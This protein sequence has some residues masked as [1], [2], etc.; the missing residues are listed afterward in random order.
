MLFKIMKIK[1][2]VVD[3]NIQKA[4]DMIGEIV[5]AVCDRFPEVETDLR[6]VYKGNQVEIL[7]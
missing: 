6:K 4:S 1:I 7:V 5:W 2:E 3:D